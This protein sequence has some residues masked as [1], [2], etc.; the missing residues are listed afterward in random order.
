MNAAQT[1]ARGAMLN[2]VGSTQYAPC[3]QHRNGAAGALIFGNALVHHRF[4]GGHNSRHDFSKVFPA[5][6]CATGPIR[7]FDL[8]HYARAGVAFAATSAHAFAAAAVREAVAAGLG[9]GI[10]SKTEFQPDER[11]R[12]LR[13]ADHKP[14]T[15]SFAACLKGRQELRPIKAFMKLVSELVT[16][17]PVQESVADI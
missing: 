8:R 5:A 9:A 7:R 15:E 1:V 16:L 4:A 11:L 2:S 6:G 3:H 17:G 13:I 12:P 10:V 14:F